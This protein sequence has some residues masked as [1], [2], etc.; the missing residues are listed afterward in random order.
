M[1]EL[2]K[3]FAS[4]LEQ[5][6]LLWGV[7]P[8]Y[9]ERSP[10]NHK[11]HRTPSSYVVCADPAPSPFTR[12]PSVHG[13][14]SRTFFSARDFI[15]CFSRIALRLC[16]GNDPV[17]RL[18]FVTSPCSS[19]STTGTFV[20]KPAAGRSFVNA[21]YS[22]VVNHTHH[23]KTNHKRQELELTCQSNGAAV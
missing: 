7:G 19:S 17:L 9:Y 20:A 21:M 2:H 15:F 1:L 23:H 4:P 11:D 22:S 3:H 8:R 16:L 13:K 12:S 10:A 18:L 5:A 14:F 6:L